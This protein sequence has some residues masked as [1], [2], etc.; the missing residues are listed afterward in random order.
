MQDYRTIQPDG[1]SALQAGLKRVAAAALILVNVVIALMALKEQWGFLQV[2]Y[3][4]WFEAMII[5]G[6]NLLKMMVVILC[7]PAFSGWSGSRASMQNR[8]TVGFLG[9]I[10]LGFF[11]VKFAMFAFGTGMLLLM[12]PACL[13][14][15]EA[16][17]HAGGQALLV[18]SDGF[19]AVIGGP[20][21][22][23]VGIGHQPWSVVHG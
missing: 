2:L 5:G 12:L 17:R 9:L 19:Q 10:A 11:V 8:M 1:T 20:A 4:F 15:L 13:R 7:G 18:M 23:P 21:A 3:V 22:N 14:D 6:Y 16:G